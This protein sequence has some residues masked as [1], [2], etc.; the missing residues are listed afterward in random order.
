M[1]TY[2]ILRKK[3]KQNDLKIVKTG[4][5]LP[6][7]FFGPIWGLFK[8]LWL[9]SLIG[10]SFLF[11]FKLAFE[12]TDIFYVFYLFSTASSFFCG[13]FARDLLI[14]QLIK[15]NFYPVKHVSANSK[16]GAIIQYLSE[17]RSE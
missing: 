14:L 7:F 4:F 2:C 8:K 1:L 6:A 10:F 9:F 11:F 16:E 15:N 17:E 5:S 3:N 13:F 12:E